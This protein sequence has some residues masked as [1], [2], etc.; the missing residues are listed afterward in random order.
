VGEVIF[1]RLYYT[2][3]F[4]VNQDPQ[5]PDPPSNLAGVALSSSKAKLTWTDNAGNESELRVERKLGAAGTFQQIVSLP[6]DTTGFT[7]TGLE[8]HTEYVYRVMACN[9]AGC[10]APSSEVT[11]TTPALGFFIGEEMK[12]LV[13]TGR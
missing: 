7:D 3:V 5:I 8:R 1:S 4:T 9:S 11:V 13:P 12:R 6:T 10:S 2:Q